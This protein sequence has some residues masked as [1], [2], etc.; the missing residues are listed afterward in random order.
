MVGLFFLVI[1]LGMLGWG[2]FALIFGRVSL[3]AY[4]TSGIAA[5]IA[6]LIMIAP[7]PLTLGLLAIR[8]IGAHSFWQVTV[9][10]W[11]MVTTCYTAA[12]LI[13]GATH[14]GGRSSGQCSFEVDY[15]T[16]KR[17]RRRKPRPEE[18]G[19]E[20]VEEEIELA[21]EE[22]D[23]R[24][25]DRRDRDRYDRD[26]DRDRYDERDRRP[27]R[28]GPPVLFLAVGGG[29]LALLGVA[30]LVVALAGVGGSARPG[31]VAS[32]PDSPA[33]IPSI[34]GGKF[35][36]PRRASGR[37]THALFVSTPGEWVGAGKVHL[38]GPTD[39]KIRGDG[40]YLGV[41]AQRWDLT[42]QPGGR[43]PL[44]LIEYAQATGDHRLVGQSDYFRLQAPRHHDQ[45]T[46]TFRVWEMD[47]ENGN[48][49]R[50]ALDFTIHYD[51]R[52]Q[53]LHGSIRYNS[54]YE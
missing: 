21:E 2:L 16:P 18:P 11:L 29:V 1:E 20:I 10:E 5:R 9:F 54:Q 6:A 36:E 8:G 15:S 40:K 4:W 7:V 51:G 35:V 24:R 23:D 3:G 19:Y 14:E 50:L 52:P 49:T 46:A 17:K 53:P 31:L 33:E 38:F 42:V 27:A 48:V 30:M 34:R 12:I 32:G 37:T 22:Y 41:I 26:R 28:Q 44:E 39:I 47:I 13:I 25:R 45:S 43:K